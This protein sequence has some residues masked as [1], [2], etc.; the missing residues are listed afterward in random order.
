MNK[1]LMQVTTTSHTGLSVEYW[2]D[3][4]AQKIVVLSDES[5]PII[6]AQARAYREG[7]ESL[8]THYMRNAVKSDRTTLYNDFINQ[9]HQDMAEILRRL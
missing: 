7:I 8:I 9:G 1:P 5:N 4:C 2:A 6:A 3:R